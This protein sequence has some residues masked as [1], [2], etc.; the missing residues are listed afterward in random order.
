M[1]KKRI[2]LKHCIQFSLIGRLF[3]DLLSIKNDLSLV[4]VQKPSQNAQ[5]CRL[6]AAAWTK[7]RYKFILIN[8]QIDPLQ[9]NLSVKVFYN[10]PKLYQLLL[11]HLSSPP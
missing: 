6:P 3:T 9:N 7:Q 10:I 8:V 11:F 1:G 2:F 4:S 5:K